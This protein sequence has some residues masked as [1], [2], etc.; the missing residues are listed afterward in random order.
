M[1]ERETTDYSI[2]TYYWPINSLFTCV[3]AVGF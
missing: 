3:R 2:K 1:E